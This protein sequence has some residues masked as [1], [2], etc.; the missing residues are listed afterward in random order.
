MGTYPIF[1]IRDSS[2][3]AKNGVRPHFSPDTEPDGA[4]PAAFLEL[5]RKET[6]KWAEVVKKSGAKVD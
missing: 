5:V 3:I 4:G 2:A 1:L 6:P